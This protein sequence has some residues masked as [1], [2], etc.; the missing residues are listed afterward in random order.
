[1]I[2]GSGS[3]KHP[4]ERK[5]KQ[6]KNAAKKSGKTFDEYAYRRAFYRAGK[7]IEMRKANERQRKGS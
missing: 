2:Y 6:Y 7:Q 3:M 1:M 4:N 5:I